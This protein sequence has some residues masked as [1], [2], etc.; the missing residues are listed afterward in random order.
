MRNE[1]ARRLSTL[2]ESRKISLVLD[3]GPNAGQFGQFLRVDVGYHG[4]IVSFEPLADAYAK[5][6]RLTSIDSRWSSA[7]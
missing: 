5:L 6:Q 7:T 2:M 1:H 4:Q 3:V